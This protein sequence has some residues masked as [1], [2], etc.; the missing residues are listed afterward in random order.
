MLHIPYNIRTLMFK[1]SIETQKLLTRFMHINI[2]AYFQALRQNALENGET[3]KARILEK[4]LKAVSGYVDVDTMCLKDC[5]E[6]IPRIVSEH[7]SDES[8]SEMINT[9]L[10]AVFIDPFLP[11]GLDT[12]NIDLSEIEAKA[13]INADAL[14]PADE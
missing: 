8:H 9:V 12:K 3:V 6:K 7:S 10:Q 1:K 2:K 4:D 13:G 14:R 11:N 5:V